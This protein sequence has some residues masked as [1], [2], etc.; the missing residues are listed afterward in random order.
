VL[1]SAAVCLEITNSHIRFLSLT[2][3]VNSSRKGNCLFHS[4]GRVNVQAGVSLKSLNR[5]LLAADRQL[6]KQHLVWRHFNHREPICQQMP[7]VSAP[8]HCHRHRRASGKTRFSRYVRLI[9]VIRKQ[10]HSR[11]TYTYTF[12]ANESDKNSL[13]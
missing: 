6:Y 8:P 12:F 10:Q 1:H 2:M 9:T 5:G 7:L 11:N 4:S 3:L 13:F